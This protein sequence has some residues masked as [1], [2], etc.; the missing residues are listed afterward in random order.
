MTSY[1]TIY[2]LEFIPLIER[3]EITTDETL[4]AMDSRARAFAD[5]GVK[6]CI[7]CKLEGHTGVS[8]YG[9]KGVA[10]TPHW[11]ARPGRPASVVSGKRRNIFLDDATWDAVRA[12]GV[13]N[14]SNGVMLAV[15]AFQAHQ[16]LK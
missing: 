14:A 12:I 4:L 5:S 15:Q 8:Y 9:P 10:P 3:T 7:Q 13:G 11:Y 6:C 2:D 1:A 16:A